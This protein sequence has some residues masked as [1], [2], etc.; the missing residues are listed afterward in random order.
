MW[1]AKSPRIGG[2]GRGAARVL[3][4]PFCPQG[5]G[6]ATGPVSLRRFLAP[7]EMAVLFGRLPRA[8]LVVP[9]CPIMEVTSLA[10]HSHLSLDKP[11]PLV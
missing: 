11:R 6:P 8:A 3:A 2:G 4:A 10:P 5:V 1:R 7:V 9:D